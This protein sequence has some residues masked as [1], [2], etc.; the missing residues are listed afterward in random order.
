MDT[1]YSYQVRVVVDDPR[2]KAWAPTN[3]TVEFAVSAAIEGELIN[4][5]PNRELA[6]LS[7]TVTSER[8]DK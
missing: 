5:L 4:D 1:T 7:V 3:T 6:G 2:G 8:L